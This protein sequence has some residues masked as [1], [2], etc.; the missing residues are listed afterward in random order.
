LTDLTPKLVKIDA[1][2]FNNLGDEQFDASLMLGPM[3]L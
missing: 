1:T 2:D 3:V